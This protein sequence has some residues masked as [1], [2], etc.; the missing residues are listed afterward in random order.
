MSGESEQ[1]SIAEH[2][3]GGS[4]TMIGVCLTVI[5]L[6]NSLRRIAGNVLTGYADEILAID[7]FIFT[8]S[9]IISYSSLR[10]GNDRKREWIADITFFFGMG[11]MAIVGVIIVINP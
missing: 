1:K 6:F 5:A 3:F 8:I 2:V 4:T 9:A 11:I 7:A 10:R